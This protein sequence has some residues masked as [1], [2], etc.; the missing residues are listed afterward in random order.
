MIREQLQNLFGVI[1]NDSQ[2]NLKF[3]WGD[4]WWFAKKTKKFIWG[5]SQWFPAILN[6]L[7]KTEI[8][9]G[10]F[11]MI[12]KKLKFIWGDSWWFAKISEIYLEWFSIHEKLKFIWGNS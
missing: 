7:W 10:Q 1:L 9:L 3:I 6:D 11:S 12:H 2:K 4:P 5:D 8:Y